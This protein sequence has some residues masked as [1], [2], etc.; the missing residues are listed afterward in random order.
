MNEAVDMTDELSASVGFAGKISVPPGRGDR[1][2][3]S[4]RAPC[5]VA[6]KFLA[7][8]NSPI[9]AR[10]RE[11]DRRNAGFAG[12]NTGRIARMR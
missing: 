12:F 10:R 5:A 2:P 9:S 1:D 4:R 6:A 3:H 11:L 8:A 7:A